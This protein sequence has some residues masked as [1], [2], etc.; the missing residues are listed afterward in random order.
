MLQ[1]SYQRTWETGLDAVTRVAASGPYHF[2]IFFRVFYT[3]TFTAERAEDAE[4]RNFHF[5]LCSLRTLSKSFLIHNASHC[6]YTLEIKFL[7]QR[8]VYETIFHGSHL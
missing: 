4:S 6:S 8:T 7:P 1:L 3:G 5:S 2:W